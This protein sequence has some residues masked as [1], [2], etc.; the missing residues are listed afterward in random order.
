SRMVAFRFV[1]VASGSTSAAPRAPVY[2]ALL[3]AWL[4]GRTL[5]CGLASHVDGDPL[6]GIQVML[7]R[8]GGEQG[9][10]LLGMDAE[11]GPV[12][13]PHEI[14]GV[15]PGPVADWV[16]AFAAGPTPTRGTS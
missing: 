7:H 5:A 11:D 6:K 14:P 9:P 12:V 15:E 16:V 13:G 2:G 3:A 10:C 8:L 4:D 1:E